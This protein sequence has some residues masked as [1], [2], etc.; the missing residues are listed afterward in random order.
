M[1]VF[2]RAVFKIDC[3]SSLS[4]SVRTS[5]QEKSRKHQED[6]NTDPW[7]IQLILVVPLDI[8]Y[9][10]FL[11]KYYMHWRALLNAVCFWW[12][13]CP[14]SSNAFR[15]RYGPHFAK[16][17]KMDVPIR[18][19]FSFCWVC[20]PCF[21]ISIFVQLARMEKRFWFYCVSDF[22]STSES[23]VFLGSGAITNTL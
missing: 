6:S 21:A 9:S 10:R 13:W 12:S 11:A 17:R 4:K 7:D 1:Y 22:G 23:W 16:V 3:H 18:V 15:R 8:V 14:L 2:Q 20:T 5:V 19:G